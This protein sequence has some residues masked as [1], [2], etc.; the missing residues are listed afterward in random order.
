MRRRTQSR[1]QPLVEMT[2]LGILLLLPMV[3]I[4]LSVSEVQRGSFGVTAAARS[5]GRAF[6]LAPDDATGRQQ[7]RAAAASRWPTRASTSP[8][9]PSRSRARLART[10]TSAAPSSPCGSRR[11]VALPFIP[12]LLG[13]AASF[14][15]DAEHHV[16]IGQYQEPGGACAMTAASGGVGPGDDHDRRSGDRARD[17]C[18]GR[19]RRIRGLPPAPGPRQPRRRRRAGRR[20]PR[21]RRRRRLRR[22][23]RRRPAGGHRRPRRGPPSTT[24]SSVPV[25]TPSTPASRCHV[26]ADP[27]TQ[28]VRVRLTAPLHLPLKVPG[29]QESALIGATGA[30]VVAVDD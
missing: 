22:R 21:R 23:P 20:R 3:W 28:T 29:G 2:W 7:A 13:G 10:A 18:R 15:L 9:G 30:A 12:D 26:D 11:S 8:T 17:G 19:H 6:A 27:A 14:G 4:V 1:Q 5:A 16:P 25:P 24:T